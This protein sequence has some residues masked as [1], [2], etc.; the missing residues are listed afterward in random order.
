MEQQNIS[1]AEWQSYACYG[2]IRIAVAQRLYGA[3]GGRLLMEAGNY[4]N[5]FESS[6]NQRNL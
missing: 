5:T 2:R 3:F 6:Q 4:Q 1:Q